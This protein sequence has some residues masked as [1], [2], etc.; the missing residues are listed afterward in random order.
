[1]GSDDEGQGPSPEYDEDDYQGEGG[2]DNDRD[3][4]GI[5]DGGV[6][7]QDDQDESWLGDMGDSGEAWFHDLGTFKSQKKF[8]KLSEMAKATWDKFHLGM[9]NSKWS[10]KVS[11][12]RKDARRDPGDVPLQKELKSTNAILHRLHHW[13]RLF[14]PENTHKPRLT[15][16]PKSRSSGDLAK[17]WM[18]VSRVDFVH[19]CLYRK[20]KNTGKEEEFIEVGSIKPPGAIE[21]SAAVGTPT[22]RTAAPMA[23]P[24]RS[25]TLPP[26]TRPQT[27]STTKP[28]QSQRL[29][30]RR[31]SNGGGRI[32]PMGRVASHFALASEESEESDESAESE[33]SE[34]S[35]ESAGSE[36]S[37]ESDGGS[38][39]D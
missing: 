30:K 21:G 29:Q 33:E 13:K 35:A 10:T 9:A 20:L 28:R 4:A 12:L 18:S 19:G 5:D 37:E 36:E 22:G 16:T 7:D 1:V 6:V 11:T 31:Q 38:A 2:L 15:G 24:K 27:R 14:E 25:R 23:T 32:R 8:N 26:G 3:E 17:V 39:S 34:E